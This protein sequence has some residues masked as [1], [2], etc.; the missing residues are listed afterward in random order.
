MNAIIKKRLA[1][2]HATMTAL[3]NNQISELEATLG[4]E[5]LDLASKFFNNDNLTIKDNSD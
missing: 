2:R 5:H 4:R 1:S 3:V